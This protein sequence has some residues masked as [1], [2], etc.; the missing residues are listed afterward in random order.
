MKKHL[1]MLAFA[2]VATLASFGA[3][4]ATKLVVGASN[5]PHAEILEQAKPILAKEGI[6]AEVIDLRTIRP[7]DTDTIVAMATAI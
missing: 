1:L 7:M 3:T 4:A 2:S 6:E 5:V